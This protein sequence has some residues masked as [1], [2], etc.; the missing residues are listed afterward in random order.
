MKGKVLNFEVNKGIIAADD[1]NRY[2][3][4]KM[5]LKSDNDPKM[6]DEVDFIIED[7]HAKEIYTSLKAPVS[8]EKSKIAAGLL[9]IFLGGL[10]IHKF[11]IGCSTAG[12]IMLVVWLF[13]LVLFGFPSFIIALIGLIE[14]IIY[15][16]K[17]DEDFNTIYVK[18]QKC[19]F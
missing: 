19:W 1:G 5:D 14:G 6:G 7:G 10:G 3:F 13:G 12:I 9:G 11:Y 4:V 16:V 17:S 15:L 2:E 8:G 18:N